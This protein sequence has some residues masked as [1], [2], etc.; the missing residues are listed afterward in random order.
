MPGDRRATLLAIERASARA[1]SGVDRLRIAAAATRPES[2][3]RRAGERRLTPP[4][5][6]TN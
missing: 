3:P 5:S 1:S 4:I 2:K 6:A